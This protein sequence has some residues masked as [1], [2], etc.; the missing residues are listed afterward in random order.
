MHSIQEVL[1][2]AGR[3]SQFEALQ[4]VQDHAAVRGIE[5]IWDEPRYFWGEPRGCRA[6]HF[7]VDDQL[8]DDVRHP[9]GVEHA[10]M[11]ERFAALVLEDQHHPQVVEQFEQSGLVCAVFDALDL[12]RSA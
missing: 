12:A 5:V 11:A 3:I 8:I 7:V 1:L 2:I 10:C 9:V 6:K 4:Q